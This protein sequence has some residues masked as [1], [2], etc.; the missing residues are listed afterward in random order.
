MLAAG[1]DIVPPAQL[2]GEVGLTC[3]R[4]KFMFVHVHRPGHGDGDGPKHG[5][6]HKLNMVT[7]MDT[8]H[9]NARQA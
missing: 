9:G 1:G 2:L 5:Q 6:G 3:H 4:Y 7:G 8:G